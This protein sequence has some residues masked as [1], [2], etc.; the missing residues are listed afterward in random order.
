MMSI[1]R[2]VA[3]AMS[4]LGIL[5]SGMVSDARAAPS[6]TYTITV[7]DGSNAQQGQ[8]TATMDVASQLIT[9]SSGAGWGV[10]PTSS[11]SGSILNFGGILGGVAFS[12][13]AQATTNTPG[14]AALAYLSAGYSTIVNNSGADR[15]FELSVI[16]TEYAEP[17]SPP[18]LLFENAT[19]GTLTI[20]SLLSG[21]FTSTAG[22]SSGTPITFGPL[23]GPSSALSMNPP[24]TIITTSATYTMTALYEATITSGTRLTSGGGTVTLTA[25]PEP[26]TL[27]LVLGALPLMGLAA[28]R[29][30]VRDRN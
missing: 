2:A 20:G 16:A 26:S 23:T 12:L 19:S 6:L 18:D 5:A 25:V 3:I 4:A 1:T 30:R 24:G 7:Y 11:S 9:S 22:S 15:R 28:Y 8:A 14:T 10:D 13:S 21:S 29:R 27:A 17:V